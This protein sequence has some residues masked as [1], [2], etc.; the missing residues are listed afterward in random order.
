MQ[1]QST[2]QPNPNARRFSDAEASEIYKRAAQIESKTLFVDE[3][4][5]RDQL[6]A[7]ANSAGLSDEA[8]DA[9]IAQ[10]EREREEA[11]SRSVAKSRTRRQLLV[12]GGLFVALVAASGGLTQRGLNSR[13]GATE[14]A[15]SNM[16]VAL[17]RRHDLI[18]SI[19]SLARKNLSSQRDL[20]AAL[21]RPEV[22][23]ATVQRIREL[24]ETRG[25]EP[26]TLDEIAGTENRI[27]VAR[28]DY[29]DS[30]LAYNRSVRTF[31]AS[32]WRKV[33][34][35][36]ERLEPFTADKGVQTAPTF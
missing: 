15:K 8:V 28:R 23:S 29:N 27:T 2:P 9:A 10:M 33:F 16:D 36:P 1:D 35:F 4:L 6:E 13:L 19:L 30:V 12:A 20:I 18:P 32:A 14:A 21:K 3:T 31:P 24:L 11:R 26:Q 7:A 34:G 17:Q 25:V 22:D 5:S